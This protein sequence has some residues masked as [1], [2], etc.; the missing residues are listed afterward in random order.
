MKLAALCLL[1]ASCSTSPL[2]D[3]VRPSTGA[4]T[5]YKDSG[6]VVLKDTDYFAVKQ[7]ITDLEWCVN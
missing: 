6:E 7:Y 1:I 5:Y 4:A 2:C 3:A